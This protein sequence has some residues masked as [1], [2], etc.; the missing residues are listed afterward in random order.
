MQRDNQWH[1]L[2]QQGLPKSW[3]SWPCTTHRFHTLLRIRTCFMSRFSWFLWC[4]L[5]NNSSSSPTLYVSSQ[6]PFI[7]LVTSPDDCCYEADL[8]LASLARSTNCT[9]LVLLSV[10]IPWDVRFC[11]FSKKLYT[12]LNTSKQVSPLSSCIIILPVCSRLYL[13][14]YPSRLW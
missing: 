1:L 13:S 12:T 3:S 14:I 10:L 4:L 2:P 6:L 7:A 8:H 11:P 5:A 9:K